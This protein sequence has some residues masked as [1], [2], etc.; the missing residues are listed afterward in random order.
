MKELLLEALA[1]YRKK[2]GSLPL[3]I[4]IIENKKSPRNE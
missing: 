2:N 3:D 1:V 4:V